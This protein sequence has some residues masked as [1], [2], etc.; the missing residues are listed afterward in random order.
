MKNDVRVIDATIADALSWP[1]LGTPD[2]YVFICRCTVFLTDSKTIP[3][4][5]LPSLLL[6]LT[7]QW[8]E[9]ED[10]IDFSAL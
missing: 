4:L 5:S 9:A 10:F 6:N 1:V 3:G 2:S 8:P 7:R